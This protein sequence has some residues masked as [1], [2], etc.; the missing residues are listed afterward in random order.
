MD[1]DRNVSARN[2]VYLNIYILERKFIIV[3]CCWTNS[4][5]AL[6]PHPSTD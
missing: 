2:S 5:Y 4:I 1:I 3:S 6:F